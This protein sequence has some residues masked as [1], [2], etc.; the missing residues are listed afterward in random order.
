MNIIEEKVRYSGK[1]K[2]ELYVS[3]CGKFRPI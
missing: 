1:T 3:F 2:I